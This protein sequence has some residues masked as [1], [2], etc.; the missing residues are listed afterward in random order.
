MITLS[1]EEQHYL[2]QHYFNDYPN[3]MILYCGVTRLDF[4]EVVYSKLTSEYSTVTALK[5][6]YEG[7]W[8]TTPHKST[9]PFVL[10][11]SMDL[12]LLP[13]DVLC[14]SYVY[15]HYPVTQLN[16]E[17]HSIGD[18]NAGILAKWCLNKNK[19]T[20]LQELILSNNELTSE[21]MKHV[22]KIVTSKPHYIMISCCLQLCYDY[23]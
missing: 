10:N 11:V 12:D 18:K 5:C 17:E 20:K 9:P 1:Q 6:L 22:I 16:I 13:Y 2:L 21:G 4:H 3:I 8:N 19:T 15:C 7:Q 23:R 14:L